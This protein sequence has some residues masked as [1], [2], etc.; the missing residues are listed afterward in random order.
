MGQIGEL[1]KQNLTVVTYN[2]YAGDPNV[3]P[4]NE[5]NPI[6]NPN[7]DL[8]YTN[9]I[10]NAVEGFLG[11]GVYTIPT[12]E[13]D[14]PGISQVEVEIDGVTRPHI[15]LDWIAGPTFNTWD[16]GTNY[17][18]NDI[19]EYSSTLYR[20][21]RNNV[22]AQPDISTDDWEDF[23]S[24]SPEL[25]IYRKEDEDSRRLL[26]TI[27][28]PSTATSYVDED[29]YFGRNYTYW[30]I[31]Q[32]SNGVTS[33]L[34]ESKSITTGTY[35]SPIQPT[36]KI[37]VNAGAGEI[38]VLFT[39]SP[40]D[41]NLLHY[42]VEYREAD[43]QSDGK[44]GFQVPALLKQPNALGWSSWQSLVSAP[45]NR[46]VHND[47]PEN[48]VFQ[49]RY[50]IV[51]VYLLESP[52]NTDNGHPERLSDPTV[53][54]KTTAADDQIKGYIVEKTRDYHTPSSDNN[55][56]TYFSHSSMDPQRNADFGWVSTDNAHH[57]D[58]WF[59][60]DTGVIMQYDASAEAWE[61]NTSLVILSAADISVLTAD[62]VIAIAE[63]ATVL[64]A[65]KTITFMKFLI[66]SWGRSVKKIES[67]PSFTA[68]VAKYD[69]L[70]VY[71]NNVV[72]GILSDMGSDS[73]VDDSEIQLKFGEYYE[74]QKNFSF[75]VW[76][77][78]VDSGSLI[79]LNITYSAF[80]IWDKFY[81][82]ET[83]SY[84]LLG[85]GAS[86]INVYSGT[87]EASVT[88]Q[89]YD[90]Y[91][92]T[93]TQDVL[94]ASSK[95]KIGDFIDITDE[96]N[97]NIH[98]LADSVNGLR[99]VYAVA[100]KA[101]VPT[102]YSAGDIVI[103]YSDV[104]F[105]IVGDGMAYDKTFGQ[106]EIYVAMSGST[107]GF[108]PYEWTI[109][110]GYYS[111]T[112]GR[113]EI[114][115]FDTLEDTYGVGDVL[116][117][118]IDETF[119]DPSYEDVVFN[120][121]AIYIAILESTGSFLPDS[122]A[123]VQNIEEY[124]DEKQATRQV[125][126]L[127]SKDVV[128]PNEK[129][130]IEL[131]YK[132]IATV[133]QQIEWAASEFR[134]DII[135]AEGFPS[136][137]EIQ[138]LDRRD[139]VVEAK[140]IIHSILYGFNGLL[141][142]MGI[143]TTRKGVWDQLETAIDTW[144][145]RR[146]AYESEES[147]IS[148]ILS[149][150]QTG[151][152]AANALIGVTTV[153]TDITNLIATAEGNSI[154]LEWD[155]PEAAL[156]NLRDFEIQCSEDQSNWYAPLNDSANWRGSTPDESTYIQT[157]TFTHSDIPHVDGAGDE[158]TGRTV[159]YRIRMR[160]KLDR[161]SSSW[162]TVSATTKGIVA[163]Q[164]SLTYAQ[165]RHKAG[166]AV[167]T[168]GIDGIPAYAMT[169]KVISD[170]FEKQ[171]WE[172]MVYRRSDLA[173]GPVIIED[174]STNGFVLGRW[175][176]FGGT[177]DLSVVQSGQSV[178]GGQVLEIGNNS[179]GE[180][181]KFLV[182]KKSI[183]FDPEKL[184][185]I[186]FRARQTAGTPVTSVGIVGRNEADAAWV[187]R[188]GVD[189][190]TSSQHWNTVVSRT[191]S[192]GWTEYIGYFGAHYDP[193]DPAGSIISGHDPSPTTGEFSDPENPGKLHP[194]AKYF[195]LAFFVNYSGG[196][197]TGN[198]IV[199]IDFIQLEELDISTVVRV[200]R[201]LDYRGKLV[202]RIE[203]SAI[204]ETAYDLEQ[205]YEGDFSQDDIIIDKD[206]IAF[207]RKNQPNVSL[208]W[209]VWFKNDGNFKFEKRITNSDHPD[210]NGGLGSHYFKTDADGFAFRGSVAF[211][212][213][214]SGWSNLEDRPKE[215]DQNGPPIAHWSFDDVALPPKNG[216]SQYLK[217]NGD[218]QDSS[219]NG[220]DGTAT[221]PVYSST[222]VA[223]QSFSGGTSRLIDTN[224]QAGT[225]TVSLWVKHS[226]I[227]NSEMVFGAQ[228]LN[229]RAYFGVIGGYF[230]VGI[231][232][233]PYRADFGDVPVRLE[234]DLLEP[235]LEDD[236]NWHHWVFLWDETTTTCTVYT[237]GVYNGVKSSTGGFANL[238]WFL[239]AHN[240]NGSAGTWFNG[241]IDEWIVYDRLISASEIQ[242]LY[243]HGKASLGLDADGNTKRAI[244]KDSST[245]AVD[246]TV[247]GAQ[248]VEGVSGNALLFDGVDD[249]VEAIPQ[250]SD[251]FANTGTQTVSV[252]FKSYKDS[253]SYMILGHYHS[254]NRF[255]I[256]IHTDNGIRIQ[257]GLA[258]HD[259]I[260]SSDWTEGVWNHLVVTRNGTANRSKIY[261]NG[262]FV[263]EVVTNIG[264]PGSAPIWLGSNG[265]SASFFKGEI[266]EPRI[267]NR[268]LQAEEIQYLYEHPG[269]TLDN[270][271]RQ[272]RFDGSPFE[273]DGGKVAGIMQSKTNPDFNFWDLE[274][275]E[276]KVGIGATSY[277]WVRPEQ[278]QFDIRGLE[279]ELTNSDLK[280]FFAED[281]AVFD[282]AF[283]HQGN[284]LYWH[285]DPGG[286]PDPSGVVYSAALLYDVG[287]GSLVMR[288][289]SQSDFAHRFIASSSNAYSIHYLTTDA[290]G[291]QYI[292]AYG[293][294]HG[295]HA[296]NLFIK[297]TISGGYIGFESKRS[298]DGAGFNSLVITDDG[299]VMLNGWN[300]VTTGIS[301]KA[302]DAST[303]WKLVYYAN[304]YATAVVSSTLYHKVSKWFSV[305]KGNPS[306]NGTSTVPDSQAKFSI[307]SDTGD[308]WMGKML[309]MEGAVKHVEIKYN[310]TEDS[311]D[312]VF[313]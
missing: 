189:S 85:Q 88:P 94:L 101:S 44:G 14:N 46:I 286:N 138:I 105:T 28:D 29:A 157:N 273:I 93:D 170:S 95:A 285:H 222:A 236:T 98:F 245:T 18:D 284:G 257:I 181:G 136:G 205:Q 13:W 37:E 293:A 228:I 116:V 190:V 298:V 63:K 112:T 76:R 217:L 73:S 30:L 230:Q 81:S 23:S 139:R 180:D 15:T 237:D 118:A 104:V 151:Y 124:I 92:R 96:A 117:P 74:S 261:L 297:N 142:N 238:D 308:I 119:S 183:P 239:G 305:G 271:W 109:A 120:A 301:P 177:N 310:E 25:H 210:Y 137:Y 300:T 111:D 3:D 224:V 55:V 208:S 75:S 200:Q 158:V 191:I 259:V 26:V 106:Y 233:L 128:T 16:I 19:V 62:S 266:D 309:R 184:Y 163:G 20:A 186:R 262:T 248:F 219:G 45:N 209:P 40:S 199:Q 269:G 243:N 57:G 127:E 196:N 295:S 213:G 35:Q 169:G 140:D 38:G 133:T 115:V 195:R 22:G 299:Q 220:T 1:I 227:G 187:N 153:P 8:D 161:V 221:S 10:G 42:V 268:E 192:A 225:K 97:P 147:S 108:D 33:L 276:F 39:G 255:Y 215:P 99:T 171:D 135:G 235:H 282:G 292:I 240:V 43:A 144:S 34:S 206:K 102:N 198:G 21:K 64:D 2:K 306:S 152:G 242:Q 234:D 204:D 143:T 134:F 130:A 260:P 244:V 87:N 84:H 241:L 246:G 9:A 141:L 31:F 79:G 80:S 89:D 289:A 77:E 252:W 265:F 65:W 12:P 49:Y 172:Y 291:D 311:I 17:V 249:S 70:N 247:Y 212:S 272:W 146:K 229:D 188:L 263:D 156:T 4:D 264:V 178:A 149:Q 218:A 91:L 148:R 52:Y 201:A 313:N 56:S 275:G 129:I 58:T 280:T 41:A 250:E 54:R 290:A 160:T 125:E 7:I 294:S 100:D 303:G 67:M 82:D 164:L 251:P 253:D 279:V 131:E 51:N 121:D 254:S 277:I 281:G 182:W 256:A 296:N 287:N 86:Q 312:F 61:P 6:D 216:M 165:S 307:D 69:A 304:T 302:A 270:L 107:T 83:F 288:Y 175:Q 168:E 176:H 283:A 202:K 185:R 71:L 110:S 50:K 114:K 197:P 278:N 174:L 126:L 232:Q 113:G 132:T 32:D 159:Y 223:G 66:E 179:G 207:Y 90:V 194:A 11:G 162:Q 122:W 231:G 60:V 258:A 166:I 193:N 59:Q 53:P 214:S 145:D 150:Y 211:A 68:L 36:D 24:F 267:Y 47:L 274:T 5:L 167:D 173:T 155:G 123:E 103:F 72:D 154:V 48:K 27:P 203:A 226:A 78:M